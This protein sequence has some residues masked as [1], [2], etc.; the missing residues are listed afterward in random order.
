MPTM[1]PETLTRCAS[2]LIPSSLATMREAP[3]KETRPPREICF[4]LMRFS[5]SSSESPLSFATR[6][7]NS[8][9][10]A[11]IIQEK[12]QGKYIRLFERF[13]PRP[14]LHYKSAITYREGKIELY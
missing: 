9:Y 14:R 13:T 6:I 7:T 2:N 3:S 11:C 10:L 5:N 12:K 4:C 8:L 1:S